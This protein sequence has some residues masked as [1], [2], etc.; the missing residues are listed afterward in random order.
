MSRNNQK[1]NKDNLIVHIVLLDERDYCGYAVKGMPLLPL[2]GAVLLGVYV[3]FW[4]PRWHREGVRCW[5]GDTLLE[6]PQPAVS[7]CCI[8]I[9]R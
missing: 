8:I 5:L 9:S 3:Y 1:K 2:N 7:S 4:M 6:M